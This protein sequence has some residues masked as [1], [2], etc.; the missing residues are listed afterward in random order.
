MPLAELLDALGHPARSVRLTAQRVLAANT[1]GVETAM[2]LDAL[3]EFLVSPK[4]SVT[5]RTHALWA[6]E[7]LDEAA[8]ARG[9][10]LAL[11]GGEDAALAAQALRQ[12][13]QRRV[14]AGAVVAEKQLAHTA[15]TVRLQ[16]ATALARMGTATSAPVLIERLAEEPDAV[17]TYALFTTLGPLGAADAAVWPLIVKSLGVKS[18]AVREGCRFALRDQWA[19]ALVPLLRNRAL[20]GR[21]KSR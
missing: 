19:E 1:C 17:V 18:Q 13:G 15:A 21:L 4:Q 20:R 16:A 3:K 7:A 14:A 2:L 10:V 9:E 5:A 12:L 8:S 6:L 11:A